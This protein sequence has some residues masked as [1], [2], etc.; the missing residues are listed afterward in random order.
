MTTAAL[1]L[2]AALPADAAISMVFPASDSVVPVT[3][4]PVTEVPP[5][6]V[7]TAAVPSIPLTGTDGGGAALV[8]LGGPT[9]IP[10]P[11]DFPANP[12]ASF[13]PFSSVV[14]GHSETSTTYLNMDGT[15][16]TDF[17]PAP[18]NTQRGD[19]SWVPIN[20]KVTADPALGGFSVVD[21]PL[22]PHFAATNGGV[23]DL[24]VSH[25]GSTITESLIGATGASAVTPVSTIFSTALHASVNSV[26]TYPEV[27]PGQ[28][29]TYTV[30]NS[31]VQQ[32]LILKTAPLVS[33]WSWLVTAPGLTLAKNSFGTIDFTDAAG[34]VQFHTPIAAIWDSSG[35]DGPTDSA[36]INSSIQLSRVGSTDKWM[37]TAAVDPAWLH[38]PARVYPVTVDP[39]FDTAAASTRGYK[40]DGTE[41]DDSARIGNVR[42]TGDNYWRTAETF[43]MHSIFGSEVTS[44]SLNAIVPQPNDN[45]PNGTY[46]SYAGTVGY[47]GTFGY[48][49]QNGAAWSGLTIAT[50]GSATD[51][52]LQ[53]AIATWIA[54]SSGGNYVILD[55]QETAGLYTYKNIRTDM[56]VTTQA[57]PT[58]TAVAPSPMGGARAG[59]TPTFTLNSTDASG[60]GLN[61]VYEVSTNANPDVSPVFTSAATSSPTLQVPRG[62]LTPGVTYYWKASAT[63]RYGATAY[64]TVNSWVANT[65]GVVSQAGSS[66]ADQSI[67]NSLTPT[68]SIASAGTDANGDSLTYQ[69]RISTGVDGIG[70]QV[71]AS[72][73]GTALSWQ[74]PAGILHDGGTYVWNVIVGDGI[75]NTFGWINRTTISQR[76]VNPGPAPT[77]SAGPVTVNLANG[78]LNASFSSPTVSTV[79]GAMG[80]SFNYNSKTASNAG[81]TGSYYDATSATGNPLVF[82]Y[83]GRSPVLVRTDSQV[84]FDWSTVS[85]GSAV[86]AVKYMAQWDGYLTPPTA[87]NYTF[88]FIRD[89]GAR[90]YLGAGGATTANLVVD[91]WTDNA[92]AGVIWNSATTAVAGVP[93][94][95]TIQY[96]EN[97]GSGHVQLWEKDSSGNTSVVPASWFTRTVR[98]LPSGWASTEPILGGGNYLSATNH[99][100]YVTLTDTDGGTHTYTKVLNAT[101]SVSSYVAPVGEVGILTVDALNNISF[102]DDTG[103]VY[104]FNAAGGVTSITDPLDG[105]HPATPV[106]TYRT[107]NNASAV[108]ELD[109]V[110]DPLSSNGATPPVYAKQVKFAYWGETAAAVG[111]S[112]ADVTDT[113][114][115]CRIPTGYTQPPADMICRVIFPGHVAGAAD[116]TELFYDANGQLARISDPGTELTDFGYTAYQGQYLLSAIRSPLVNDWLAANTSRSATGPVTTT[117]GYDLNTSNNTADLT[118]GFATSVTLPAPD[119]TTTSLQPSKNYTYASVPTSSVNGTTYIDQTGLTVPTTAPSNGHAKTVTFNA[120][121]QVQ[122]STSALGFSLQSVWN[123]HDNLLST[124]DAA[125]RESSTIYDSQDRPTDTYGPAPASCFSSTTQLPS[126]SCTVT[127]AHTSTVYDGGMA[128]LN[129]VFYNNPYLTGI[130]AAFALGVG[131]ADGSVNQTFSTAP[132][133][134]ITSTNSWSMSL[135][136]T[137]TFPAAG[138]YPLTISTGNTAQL[139]VNDVLIN[140]V[141]TSGSQSNAF[142][143]TAGQ[144][145]R[146]RLVYTQVTSSAAVSLS[147]TPPGGTSTIIPGSALSPN[148]SLTTKT[149]SSDSV[150]AV[151]GV[152]SSQVTN[153][154]SSTGYTSP[155]LGLATSSI[156]GS[157]TTALTS[158]ATYETASTGY[159]RQLSSS[160]PAGANTISTNIYY[161]AAQSYGTALGITSPVC[162]LPVATVQYG[163]VETTTGPTP[164]VGAAIATTNIY[165]LFGRIVGSKTAS[166][167]SWTCLTYDTRSRVATTSI[168]A[169]GIA[170]A[171]TVTHSF[172]ADNTTTGD[173]LTTWVQDNTTTGSTTAGKITTVTDLLGRI[174][175]Y[176]DVWGTVTTNDYN[177]LSQLAAQHSTPAA[178]TTKNEEFTYDIDGKTKSVLKENVAI[179]NLTYDASGQLTSINYPPT[180]GSNVTGTYSYDQTG[181]LASLSWGFPNSQNTV[182]DSVIRSQTGR[183]LMDTT[184]DGSTSSQSTYTYDSN[185]RL[186]TAAIPHHALAYSYSSSGGCGADTAAGADGNRTGYSDSKDGATA[187][188][189]AYCYDNADRLTAT[190]VANPVSGATPIAGMS[191]T[192]STLIYDAHGNTT[193]LADQ[194]MTYDGTNRHLSTSTTGSNSV[195]YVRD[196]TDRI[197]SMS[198]IVNGA[199]A[200]VVRYG[201]ASA[202]DSPDWTLNTSGTVL[203]HTLG[204]PGGVTVSIQSGGGTWVWSYPNIH[205]DV[206]V[207]TGGGGTRSGTLAQYD[208]FGDLVDA[209]S[210]NI[211][212]S[213]ADDGGPVNTTTGTAGYGWEGSHE[214]LSQHV[215]DISTIEMGARQY[216]AL[217]GRFLSMDPVLGGNSNNYNYPNDPMNSQDLSGLKSSPRGHWP[218]RYQHQYKNQVALKLLTHY[219]GGTGKAFHISWSYFKERPDFVAFAKTLRI[220][221]PSG[222]TSNETDMYLAL[223]S[224]KVIRTSQNS[225]RVSDTYDFRENGSAHDWVLNQ[226]PFGWQSRLGGA[227]DFKDYSSG[228]F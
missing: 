48:N 2:G 135:T 5:L 146:I 196:A 150:P 47:E 40:T 84:S 46:N 182:T 204:L 97:L 213:A 30:Q 118:A 119:G 177:I 7:G 56:Y 49:G 68:L 102:T 228:S 172:T 201:Y 65:P 145:A 209:T 64:T 59:V 141:T 107:A 224:F 62:R 58:V 94:P 188:T 156:V 116:T 50:T 10:A 148:Y 52:P 74:V 173:P 187:T 23:A 149:T 144:V 160:K 198:T 60:A 4:M 13:N 36:L 93:T 19:G 103:T 81:L 195:S 53:N 105:L 109:S 1:V 152:T 163:M 169:F 227:R 101:S 167:T 222:F 12:K 42:D 200:T 11:V 80:L 61:Y 157:G 89:D 161:G 63:D 112:T 208:P 37:M 110:S 88:G 28:D 165:D 158:S 151:T 121:L 99:E 175:S 184:A 178:Q 127:P 194:T 211:G 29:L 179:A 189:T 113:S 27:F 26:V 14:S 162:G 129:T 87:G 75:D 186:T 17:S 193:T 155:W 21:N 77:D 143:A 106:L 85:P 35:K 214:K 154:V 45:G 212:T 82:S 226:S 32:A 108:N 138:S 192:S 126:G 140:N 125:S 73:V 78:N 44:V 217:L 70:G 168:P 210:N 22:S 100:G 128:G 159:M 115:A 171:R 174:T 131:T 98:N 132:N 86:P 24:T 20:N 221:V 199:T 90:L 202:D 139:F 205:G 38:S 3:T 123:N 147:W 9:I 223:G 117:I 137:L 104:L 6:P 69:F 111:L 185:G 114:Q 66:P 225:Y 142:I 18:V 190:T 183:I 215:G 220:G 15:S 134:A 191:L 181:A 133:P 218:N 197:V 96:Y 51:Q 41:L 57:R 8:S 43:D 164:A 83:S 25:G 71:A 170:A 16:T 34:V 91:Q 203:E 153:M 54:N 72:A 31:G 136:G 33:T 55:G 92:A 124:V 120:A 67:I 130:P 216:V 39:A 180:P 76:I 206:I 219:Y 166:D 207:T 122:S 176:T 95:I 79:G